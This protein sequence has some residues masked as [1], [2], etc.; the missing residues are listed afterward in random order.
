MKRFSNIKRIGFAC[1]WLDHAEQLTRGI[2]DH[3]PA[4]ALHTSGTTITWLNRQDRAVAEERLWNIMVHNIQVTER[5]VRKI[6]EL[7]PSKRMVR[8]G[9]GILPGYTEGTWK[10]FWKRPDVQAYAAAHFAP[11]GQIAKSQDVR[12]SFHPGPYCV[13][14]SDNDDIVARSVEEFEYHA[15]MARWM[16]FGQEF[17]DLKINVHISGK[18][19]AQGIVDVYGRLTP[20]ARNCITIENE[21]MKHG[22]DDCLVLTNHGI[23]IVIDIHHH[24]VREGEYIQLADRRVQMVLEGWRGIR[25]VLH[26]SVSRED[27]LVD[28][29]PDQLPDNRLL[30]EAGHKKSKLRAHSDFYWNTAATDNALQFLECFDIMCEAKAKNLASFVVHDRAKELGLC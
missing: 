11:I 14:A 1:D 10:H 9:S 6:S 18:R 23:P 19:G 26:Y 2:K 21:E 13:M 22:L 24:W 8:L 28:H 27:I 30:L 16:G 4:K 15:D 7:E 5:L 12:L 17:Q 3:E 25:P 29:K 20:E